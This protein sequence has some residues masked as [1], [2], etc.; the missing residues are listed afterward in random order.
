MASYRFLTTWLIEA[1]VEP[2]WELIYD[3]E[4]WPEWWRGVESVEELDPGGDDK[5]GSVARHRWRSFLPYTVEFTSRTTT[6][7]RPWLIEGTTGGELAGTGRW[8]LF[9][10]GG[11]TAVLYDWDVRTTRRWMNAVAPVA[12]PAFRWNH[13]WVMSRGGEGLARRVGARLLASS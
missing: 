2:V 12:R 6:V 4:R 3:A 11:T 7:E 8:R 13:H 9:E 1:R 5:V 10:Q